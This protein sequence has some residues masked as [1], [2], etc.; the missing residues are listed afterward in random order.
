MFSVNEVSAEKMTEDGG[1]ISSF[2]AVKDRKGAQEVNEAPLRGEIWLVYLIPICT[3]I[4]EICKTM[5]TD[6]RITQ[7]EFTTEMKGMKPP[8]PNEEMKCFKRIIQQ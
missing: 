3:K 2:Q 4:D 5:D 8:K 1:R 6:G 7:S